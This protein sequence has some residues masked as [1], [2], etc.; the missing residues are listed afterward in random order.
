MIKDVECEELQKVFHVNAMAFYL[1]GKYF[2]MTKYSNKE[3]AIIAISSI[4][5][6]ENEVGRSL[7]SMTKM[8]MNTAGEV[9]A[10]E[11]LKRKIRVNAILPAMVMSKMGTKKTIGAK[12]SCKR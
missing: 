7:Y 4:S 6:K 10:K 1:M 2:G 8:A 5:S 3:S 9:M 12:K 11:F